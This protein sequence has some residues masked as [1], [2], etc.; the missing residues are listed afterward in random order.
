MATQT[1]AR[2]QVASARKGRMGGIVNELSVFLK[3]KPCREQQVREV[4]AGDD[5]DSGRPVHAQKLLDSVGTLH[6]ARMVLF[7][8]GA[9]RRIRPSVDGDWGGY[10]D[11]FA[12]T[13]VL[14]DWERLLI[15]C[16]GYPD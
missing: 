6:E 8:H 12:R 9:R 15:H 13:V 10:I 5:A 14:Q 11:D 2:N 4:F 16:E 3:L 7:R 1:D